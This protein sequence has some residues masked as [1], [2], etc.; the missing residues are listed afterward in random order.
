MISNN[1]LKLNNYICRSH[2]VILEEKFGGWFF[3]HT[4]SFNDSFAD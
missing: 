4:L 2:N 3:S 1:I